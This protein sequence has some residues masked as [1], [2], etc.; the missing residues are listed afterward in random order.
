MI[1]S[2]RIWVRRLS[3]QQCL[4][5][6]HWKNLYLAHTKAPEGHFHPFVLKSPGF[7]Q[8]EKHSEKNVVFPAVREAQQRLCLS[9]VM[10]GGLRKRNEDCKQFAVFWW[11]AWDKTSVDLCSYRSTACDDAEKD[12]GGIAGGSLL[13]YFSSMSR[14]K[15]RLICL[16]LC[17]L[18]SQ[19]GNFMLWAV[20]TGTLMNAKFAFLCKIPSL[21]YFWICNYMA[22]M[23]VFLL[24]TVFTRPAFAMLLNLR[25]LSL[26]LELFLS[27]V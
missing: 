22:S 8:W 25:L 11:Q 17:L 14:T 2:S 21:Y 13:R 6:G 19:Q 5:L 3:T 15:W 7:L 16:L 20:Q 18:M 12:G 24:M 10:L 4:G 26:I 23:L 1:K 9:V 27:L